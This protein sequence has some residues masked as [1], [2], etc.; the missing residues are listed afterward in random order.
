[1]AKVFSNFDTRQVERR[2]FMLLDDFSFQDPVFGKVQAKKGFYTNY[3]SIDVLRNV[4]LFVFYALLAEY[5]DKAA[6]LHDWLYSGYPVNSHPH[7][8]YYPTRKEA[9]QIMYR[10]LRAEGV[11]R[12]RAWMFYIGVRIGGASKFSKE[13][14]VWEL[15][16]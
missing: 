3:A 8:Y 10:A 6:T 13:K 7:T 14:R 12:W 11:A 1:M 9:D 16:A 2:L 5:G 4:L 15:T